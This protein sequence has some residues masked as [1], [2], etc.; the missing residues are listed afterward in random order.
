MTPL[1]HSQRDKENVELYFLNKIFFIKTNLMD[2]IA[3]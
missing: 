1:V 2:A 3:T